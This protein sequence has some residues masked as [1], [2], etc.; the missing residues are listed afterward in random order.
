MTWPTA[1]PQGKRRSPSSSTLARDALKRGR[2]PPPRSLRHR[3]RTHPFAS[4]IPARNSGRLCK[5][6]STSPMTASRRSGPRPRSLNPGD[7]AAYRLAE[8]PGPGEAKYRICGCPKVDS[9]RTA[10]LLAIAMDSR[11]PPATGSSRYPSPRRILRRCRKWANDRRR[12]DT[13]TAPTLRTTLEND[14]RCRPARCTQGELRE[15]LGKKPTLPHP[16]ATTPPSYRVR[17]V[18][19]RSSTRPQSPRVQPKGPTSSTRKS[20]STT[21]ST[22]TPSPSEASR[23]ADRGHLRI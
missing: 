13:L 21:E 16:F 10:S 3:R 22:G 11:P 4:S 9:T 1:A 5:S 6:P 20:S 15:A 19:S 12:S 18:A 7:E 2:S 23:P 14:T 17:C 8:R